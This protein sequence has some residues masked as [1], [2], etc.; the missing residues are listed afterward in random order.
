MMH[1]G[2]Y[3]RQGLADLHRKG[4]PAVRCQPFVPAG[5]LQRGIEMGKRGGGSR[6]SLKRPK[7]YDALRRKG[8]SKT[9]AAKISNA[10]ARKG[11]KKK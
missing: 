8:Y 11:H 3:I 2:P 6:K 5:F 1:R 4:P 7:V 9:K 10:Q